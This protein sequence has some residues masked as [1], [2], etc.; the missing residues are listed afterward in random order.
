[1]RASQRDTGLLRAV[2]PVALA[3]SLI[4]QTV[5]ATIFV[6]PSVLALNVG[7]YAPLAILGCGLAMGM[8]A[9]CFA[10]G[11]SRVPTSGGAFGYIEAAFGPLAG[12]VAGTLLWVGN[13][14]AC[15]GVSAALGDVIASLAPPPLAAP[16]RAAVILAALG[17]IAAVN[18]RGVA[19]GAGLI[20]AATLVKLLPLAIFLA[21]GA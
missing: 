19:R 12:Y 4:C 8:V 1:M 2:G 16:V 14:L 9:I 6:L 7:A 18:T 17:S 10:E 5:G 13:V 3:A 11:G 21:V 15:G 20:K